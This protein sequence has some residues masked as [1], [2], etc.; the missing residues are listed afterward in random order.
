MKAIGQILCDQKGVNKSCTY[1][2]RDIPKRSV[3]SFKER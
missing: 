3:L 2:D 1:T